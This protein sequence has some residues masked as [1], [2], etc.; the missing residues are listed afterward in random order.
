MLL[1]CLHV[2]IVQT[3]T[4]GLE[5]W[6]PFY[7]L[8]GHLFL[9]SW[10]TTCWWKL[11]KVWYKVDGSNIVTSTRLH[12][13]KDG[14]WLIVPMGLGK[15]FPLKQWLNTFTKIGDSSRL[16]ILRTTTGTEICLIFFQYLQDPSLFSTLAWTV[17]ACIFQDS[18][19]VAVGSSEWG[20]SSAKTVPSDRDG[21]IG[22]SKL[23]PQHIQ[24]WTKAG[25]F[26]FVVLVLLLF[27]L[28]QCQSA[29]VYR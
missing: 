1:W 4:V 3:S 27:N 22:Y 20:R 18:L 16:S 28:K 14:I 15:Q 6:K 13:C 21:S 7:L 19:A 8:L 5:A 29:L 12:Y 10:S 9:L 23:W 17:C 24:A 2:M 26:F 25:Y 11:Q